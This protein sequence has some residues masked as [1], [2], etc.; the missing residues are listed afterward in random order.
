M[1]GAHSS[2]EAGG[3]VRGCT[4]ALVAVVGLLQFRPSMTNHSLLVLPHLINWSPS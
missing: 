1:E 2:S 3:D 4:L